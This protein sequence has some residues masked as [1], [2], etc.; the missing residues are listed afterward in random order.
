M[1]LMNRKLEPELETVFLTAAEAYSYVSSRMVKDI[2][3]LGGSVH[4]M[5]PE[6]VE[7][8]LLRKLNGEKQAKRKA[9]IGIRMI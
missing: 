1:A 4:G 2:A 6:L 7:Q 8:R 9:K 5:V 3:R